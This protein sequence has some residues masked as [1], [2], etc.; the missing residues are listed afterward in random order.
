MKITQ[1][2]QGVVDLPAWLDK[3]PSDEVYQR[4]ELAEILA[5]GDG[6]LSWQLRRLVGTPYQHKVGASLFYGNPK[7]ILA[8]QKALKT[9]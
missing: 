1:A 3:R 4:R 8:F 5:L 7:A 6:S 2:A 9:K